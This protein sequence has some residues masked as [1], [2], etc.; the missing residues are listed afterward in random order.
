MPI[1]VSTDPIHPT[2]RQ[3][4]WTEAICRSFASIETKPLG[5]AAVSGH[6]EF[7]EIGD[8]KLVRFDSSPQCYTRDARLVSRAG[9]DEFMFD[10]QR[11]GRSAMMQAGNQ[12]TINPGYGVLYDAR[13]PFEDRLFGPEQ[14]AE[15]LIATVP[16]ASLLRT[17]PDAERLCARPVPLS[18]TMARSIAA[19]VH[20]AVSAPSAPAK[21]AESDIAAYLSALLR[22]ATGASHQLARADLFHL[23]DGYVRTNISNVRSAPALAAEFGISERTFHRIFADRDT[24]FERHVLHLRVERFRDLLRQASP[25][26]VS[27]ATLAHQCGFADAA[28]AT[29]TFKARFGATPRDFRANTS[30]A[31]DQR[32]ASDQATQ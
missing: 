28:H 30:M 2:E 15:V 4:F 16:A 31:P 10:F 17:V 23:I 13:R 29:R 3:A 8:A 12:G 5:C 25:A 19:F 24:T 26:N 9:S 27:I 22:I 1:S 32:T 6:F 7:V 20:A 11:R 14:R 18:G 21:H